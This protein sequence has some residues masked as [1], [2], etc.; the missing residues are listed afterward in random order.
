MYNFKSMYYM[1]EWDNVIV[2]YYDNYE[3]RGNVIMPEVFE[4]VM[5]K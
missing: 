1:I 3:Q 5:N 2:R 4:Y